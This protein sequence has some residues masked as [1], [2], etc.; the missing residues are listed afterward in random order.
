MSINRRDFLK[1]AGAGLGGLA[2]TEVPIPQVQSLIKQS[3][4]ES[5]ASMLYDATKCVGCKACQVA[6]KERSNLPPTTDTERIWEA[7]TDLNADTWTLIKLYDGEEGTSFVKANCMHCIEPACTSVCPVAALQKTDSGPVVYHAERCIGCRYCMAA[8]PF[9][10]PKAQWY[11][12][13]PKIQKCDFCA[14]RLANGEQPACA[15]AC[16]TGA[17]GFGSRKDMLAVAKGRIA[18]TER[19][20]NYVYG[21]KEVGGTD[22]L[23]ITGVNPLLLGLPELNEKPLPEIDWPYLKAVPWVVGIVGAF[24]TGTYF[25]THRND[26]GKEVHDGG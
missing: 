1:T 14:D 18:D 19:Y 11:S 10:I 17:I 24:L 22:V 6:C 7:P 21:E 12:N 20:V 15:D 2:L 5:Q 9:S 13:S 25:Y 23:Y 16:P 4:A 26:D 8:C 3:A